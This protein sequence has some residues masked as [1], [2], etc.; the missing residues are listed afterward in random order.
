M[1]IGGIR[2]KYFRNLKLQYKVILMAVMPVLI[3]CI[4]AIIINNTVVKNK[5][6]NDTKLELKATAKAVLAAYD[7]NT[8]DYFENT[9][10]DVWKGAYNISLSTPFIDDIDKKTGIAITFFYGDRRLVT[11]LTDS[12]GQRLVGSN[13]GEFLVKN[14]LQ[15]GNEVFTNRVLVENT[16]YFGYYIPVYQNNS[17]EIIGMIFAG[18]PVSMV[19]E[20]LNLITKV[21]AIAITVILILTVIICA[22][23]A[24]GI[25]KS[26]QSS[27]NVVQQ[28]S[29]GNLNVEIQ[30]KSLNRKDEVGALSLSTK[31]LLDNLSHIIGM[32]SENTM[33]LNASSEEM[34]AAA[35]LAS[36]AVGNINNNLQDVLTGATE[37]TGN[38]IN[39][40]RNIDNIN[41]H[42]ENT[43]V[44]VD[45]L[46]RATNSMQYAGNS[47]N[48]TLKQ[49]NITNRDVLAEIG[50]IQQ[51]TIQTNESVDRI[52][53]AVTLI[54]D[55]AEQTNLLSLNAS[56]EAARAGEAGRGFAVVAGEISTLANQSNEASAEISDIVQHLSQNS[57]LTIEIMNSVLNAINEQTQ[58]VKD[59]A[60][61]FAEVHKHI[62]TVTD[63]VNVISEATKQLVK[64][65]DAITHD[66]N[67]LS[68]IASNNE[69]TVKGTINYS[70]DVLN[71]V[72]S[73]S[74]MSVEVS[75]SANDMAEI[76][77]QFNI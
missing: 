50:N 76:V 9:A 32:I 71:T 4:V 29:E 63:G 46:S 41:K 66:I 30:E 25:A 35:G 72:N 59:T 48:D 23:V 75:S 58:S 67:N 28:I 7:Q 51:Q 26:I 12:N 37:Q 57:R 54:S 45:N 70:D 17:S 6:L 34:N 53:R 65:T 27:M 49:L 19:T 62:S 1:E 24:R 74:D 3:M 64:E 52:I 22:I 42:I 8:G 60:S 36:D 61:I 38:V 18:M 10:G 47:V 40:Q 31:K 43:L 73:V 15:D 69:N 11:S 16:F 56:I 55:I 5:L 68:D 2:L 13:A 77:S 39:I 14:V 20:S 21:F 33:T 44:Q